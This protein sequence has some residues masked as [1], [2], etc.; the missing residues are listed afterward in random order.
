MRREKR[1]NLA[2]SHRDVL[3]QNGKDIEIYIVFLKKFCRRDDLL[4]SW[5]AV[6]VHA[7]YV[8]GFVA[9]KGKPDKEVVGFENLAPFVVDECAVC[10]DS[11]KHGRVFDICAGD[12]IKSRLEKRFPG[13]QRF[14]ALKVEPDGISVG[15]GKRLFDDGFRR[16]KAH[17]AVRRRFTVF[18]DVVVKAVFTPHIAR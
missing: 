1:I 6:L 12:E 16:L 4:K 9:V 17:C 10:L 8:C 15:I 7:V 13:K 11:Q 5:V 2:D 18:C 3:C 14:A